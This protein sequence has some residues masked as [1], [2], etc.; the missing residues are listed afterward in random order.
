MPYNIDSWETREMVDFVVNLSR[1]Q[2]LYDFTVV[3][4]GGRPAQLS[5]TG[6]CEGF[7]LNGTRKRGNWM[8]VDEIHYSQDGSGSWWSDFKTALEGSTGLL[9]AYQVWEG[10]DSFTKLTVTNGKVVESPARLV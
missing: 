3:N 6:V 2:G 10:G 8:T 7:E 1:F 9:V 4:H 5:C